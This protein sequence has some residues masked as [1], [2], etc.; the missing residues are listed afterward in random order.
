MHTSSSARRRVTT[1]LSALVA[2]CALATP[3]VV[4]LT[5]AGVSDHVSD[6]SSGLATD[7]ARR[8][9]TWDVSTAA[10]P[11]RWGHTWDRVPQNP[12]L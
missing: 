5:S 1:F 8:G 3:A 9:H 10:G 4:A 11:S 2:G 6:V 7:V 12:A